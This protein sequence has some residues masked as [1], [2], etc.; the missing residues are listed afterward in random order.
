MKLHK[1]LSR[2]TKYKTL[3]TA[4]LGVVLAASFYSLFMLVAYL[5]PEYARDP[6]HWG[7]GCAAL[8]ATVLAPRWVE[9]IL[10]ED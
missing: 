7:A 10:G 9:G 2:L 5:W 6:R 1:S 3:V 8:I 4:G